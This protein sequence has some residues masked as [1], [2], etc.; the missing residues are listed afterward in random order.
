LYN[1]KIKILSFWLAP[2]WYFFNNATN[3]VTIEDPLNLNLR[4]LLSFDQINLN[5]K[6]SKVVAKFPKPTPIQSVSWPYLLSGT[7]V[8][9]VAETGSGKTFAFGVPAINNILTLG[10]TGLSVLCI[11]P[12]REL[13]LQIYDNLVDLTAKTDINCVAIYG[14]VSKEDQKKKLRNANV[15]VATP[16]RLLDLLN[17]GAVDL[18]GI[19][20]LV[21]DEADRMLEKGFEEDIK[22]I[23]GNTTASTRQT[24]MFT[25]TWPKEV[26]ELATKFMKTAV[27]VSIGDRDELAANKSITQIVE[28]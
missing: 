13:A 25:A 14:G 18:S 24:L 23:I 5:S 22:A 21:L 6:I 28:V 16:G 26:R 12:T 15:V 27:K 11:S 3:E 1:A 4:P 2:L 20:Y 19:D 10:K 9:G 7:D 17:D 8:I